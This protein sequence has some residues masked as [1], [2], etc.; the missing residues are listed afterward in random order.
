MAGLALVFL[1]F[2]FIVRCEQKE[3]LTINL[4]ADFISDFFQNKDVSRIVLYVCWPVE[5]IFICFIVNS[6]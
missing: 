1:L 4:Y 6:N 3:N 5:G 2:S